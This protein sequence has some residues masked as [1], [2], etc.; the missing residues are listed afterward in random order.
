MAGRRWL[1]F[2]GALGLFGSGALVAERTAASG[3]SAEMEA[4]S[5]PRT[6]GCVEPGGAA[7]SDRVGAASGGGDPGSRDAR[8]GQAAAHRREADG[9]RTPQAV[10][11]ADP[12]ARPSGRLGLSA[13]AG[14]A[15]GTATAA[16]ARRGGTYAPAPIAQGLEPERGLG[17]R[18]RSGTAMGFEYEPQRYPGGV[19]HLVNE[20]GRPITISFHGSGCAGVLLDG[21]PVSEGSS[22]LV[23][24]E[25]AVQGAQAVGIHVR[26]PTGAEGE[27]LP[28]GAG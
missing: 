4:A 1:L 7:G 23:R 5:A 3:R 11:Q 22:Y 14:R 18:I 26:A 27:A 19:M 9:L 2:V 17:V 20:A 8:S 10:L 24:S 15:S 6:G 12:V 28:A 16:P 13:A 21:Q 25:V